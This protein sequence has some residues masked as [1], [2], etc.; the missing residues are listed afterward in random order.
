MKRRVE[1]PWQ[2]WP[3]QQWLAWSVMPVFFAG[4]VTMILL[5]RRLGVHSENPIEDASLFLGFGAFAAVGSI[6]MAK[7]PRNPIGWI[8]AAAGLMVGVFPAGDAYAAYV[9]SSSGRPNALAIAGAW[10]GAW[11][12]FALLALIFVFLPLLFPDRRLPSRR[13]Q[14]SPVS[15]A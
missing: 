1:R 4:I 12:W 11:Y 10:V 14:V 6:L 13:W 2:R 5:Q 8:M 15:W 9:M 7:R 3:Y